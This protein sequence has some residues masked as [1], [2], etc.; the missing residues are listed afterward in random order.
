MI[1]CFDLDG[2][3]I[4]TENWVINALRASFK[5]NKKKFPGKNKFF[6]NWG[7]NSRILI[8]KTAPELTKKEI[9]NIRKDFYKTRDE[10]ISMIK[11]FKNT[12]KILRQLNKNYKLAIVSNNSHK[13]ILKIM[14]VTKLDKKLFKII[15]GDDEVKRAKPFP[16]EI[17]KTEK[18]LKKKVNFLVGDTI[19]DVKTARSAKIDSIIIKNG[20]RSSWKNLKKADFIIKDITELPKIIKEAQK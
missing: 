6:E 11:P 8:K 18:K 5:K 4:D 3:L 14:K 2:T 9:E 20:P 16:D 15:V 17:Y 19:Q 10:T 1:I 13:E 7:L 12:K